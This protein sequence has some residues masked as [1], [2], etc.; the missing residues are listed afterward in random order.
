MDT[1]ASYSAAWRIA[2]LR[3]GWIVA[4]CAP[5]VPR[6]EMRVLF[7]STTGC[8]EPGATGLAAA[9]RPA[10]CDRGGRPAVT[11]RPEAPAGAHALL[12]CC[13]TP[14]RGRP[15]TTRG[16]TGPAQPFSTRFTPNSHA[17]REVP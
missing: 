7:Q 8:P 12:I 5:G 2:K 6:M 11:R 13:H 14:S 16:R 3:V 17:F 4:G 9:G 15:G 1:T 10:C